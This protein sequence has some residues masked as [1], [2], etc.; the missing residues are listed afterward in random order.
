MSF[1][2]NRINYCNFNKI[3]PKS[4]Q[5]EDVYLMDVGSYTTKVEAE[6]ESRLSESL[7]YN[8]SISVLNT[9]AFLDF[10]M[11]VSTAPKGQYPEIAL[12]FIKTFLKPLF[13]EGDGA[14]SLSSD[15]L[16][17][18]F[19]RNQELVEMP[20]PIALY[21][22]GLYYFHT[23][24]DNFRSMDDV[25]LFKRING[26]TG[27]TGVDLYSQLDL[28]RTPCRSID[29]T[30][31]VFYP[32]VRILNRSLDFIGRDDFD[33]VT[34]VDDD[35]TEIIESINIDTK[36]IMP[37]FGFGIQN[38]YLNEF[39]HYLFDDYLNGS[40]NLDDNGLLFNYGKAHVIAGG[41]SGILKP[42]KTYDSNL[43]EFTAFYRNVHVGSQVYDVAT[44][45]SDFKTA[46]ANIA[47]G[48][49]ASTN[50][51]NKAFIALSKLKVTY[52][53]NYINGD[54]F[55]A[56]VKQLCSIKQIKSNYIATMQ[57][58]Y[59]YT[60]PDLYYLMGHFFFASFK[61]E[62]SLEKIDFSFDARLSFDASDL[63]TY[64]QYQLS[65]LGD[66]LNNF[67]NEGDRNGLT[68]C[69]TII[70]SHILNS[71]NKDNA[72]SGV[73][74]NFLTKLWSLEKYNL[75]NDFS[76]VDDKAVYTLYPSAGGFI[77]PNGLTIGFNPDGA[78][79]NFLNVTDLNYF[80]NNGQQ[81]NFTE[82]VPKTQHDIGYGNLTEYFKTQDS[83]YKMYNTS[84]N[85]NTISGVYSSNDINVDKP[86]QRNT[87]YFLDA[88][89]DNNNFFINTCFHNQNILKNT[90][91]YLWFETTDYGENLKLDITKGTKS[92]FYQEFVTGVNTAFF[93]P[94]SGY[95]MNYLTSNYLNL[96]DYATYNDMYTSNY[97]EQ[98]RFSNLLD[99][100]DFEKLEEFKS[101]FLEF[102]STDLTSQINDDTFNL[103]SLMLATA[104]VSYGDITNI[105]TAIKDDKTGYSYSSE[106][107]NLIL[108][109]NSMFS[110]DFMAASTLS[111]HMNMVLTIGQKTNFP[112][113][114]NT[115]CSQKITI[116]NYSPNGSLAYNYTS[117]GTGTPAIV[118]HLYVMSP[119]ILFSD[120]KGYDDLITNYTSAGVAENDVI[121][122]L[123][124]KILFSN[125]T[126]APYTEL[127]TDQVTSLLALNDFYLKNT[128]FT[129]T[130][131]PAG[132][133][134]NDLY[135]TIVKQFFITLNI[136]YND[137]LY[138]QLIRMIRTYAFNILTQ[139]NL[140]NTNL[141][142][143]NQ[144][145]TLETYNA[146]FNQ[147][148]S[149]NEMQAA[150]Q[151][152]L[153]AT[154]VRDNTYVAPVINP[155]ITKF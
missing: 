44:I 127:T 10:L 99:S 24:K 145:L 118:P 49:S 33:I 35:N 130:K 103:Q 76:S 7:G 137:N 70:A 42:I 85:I 143:G 102:S 36:N 111:K 72:I 154:A 5:I 153:S 146:Y 8:N 106:E 26:L 41:Y 27:S 37:S 82:Y 94:A 47:I 20:Y 54:D 138:K 139:A 120:A 148:A 115:F 43:L 39:N 124:R 6:F 101:L 152:L 31:Q 150:T 88:D 87:M 13:P 69:T 18:L 56:A 144:T 78:A 4:T 68:G 141:L 38:R 50:N 17:P 113:I 60:V 119:D 53:S 147:I 40:Y 14:I 132:L 74:T 95:V 96:D 135:L 155:Q 133:T 109:G 134:E 71:T 117:G 107:L 22:G 92:N 98:F 64:K 23:N 126:M 142:P 32:S 57:A 34:G 79:K 12:M 77:S 73:I 110:Y 15:K 51:I 48:N 84:D 16:Y 62:D 121:R 9:N 11:D 63:K 21:L 90:S 25:N 131:L 129:K 80:F 91:R 149:N 66:Y 65:G 116:A 2:Q 128:L 93:N 105:P 58:T 55:A 112:T 123:S 75:I 52:L 59:D 81:I 3:N 83:R 108:V 28:Y 140:L 61:P 19:N 86:D 100:M 114:I 30:G 122:Y 1:E 104:T 151:K 46:T 125:Q 29:P 67:L 136:G 97:N 45:L 89:F